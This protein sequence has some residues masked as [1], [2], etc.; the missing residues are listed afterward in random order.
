M[1]TLSRIFFIILPILL[2]SIIGGFVAYVVSN[3]RL[4]KTHS[5][6]IKS[7]IYQSYIN[8]IITFYD[9]PNSIEQI[10]E[11]MDRT[12]KIKSPL[13]LYSPDTVITA[14]CEI[15][16]NKNNIEEYLN[17]IANLIYEMR[18]DIGIIKH[19][20]KLNKEYIL[21]MTFNHD[22][23]ENINETIKQKNNIF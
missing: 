23:I 3:Y 18:I 8:N 5:F 6:N 21:K 13:L 16:K 4:K 17:S 9:N 19:P 10:N 2:S 7:K 20:K 1:Y 12:N 15:A 22:F 14:Y 11:I